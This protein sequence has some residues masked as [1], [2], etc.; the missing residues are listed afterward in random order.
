MTAQIMDMIARMGGADAIGAMAAKLGISPEQTQSAVAA[1]VPGLAG[2]MAKQ[3]QAGN[4]GLVDQLAGAAAALTSSAASDEAVAQGN[5]IVG[6]VLDAD[7][8]AAVTAKAAAAS[9]LDASSLS[10]LMPMVATMA[11]SA[12]GNGTG[13]VAAPAGGGIGG[14]LGGLL[15]NLGGGQAGQGGAAS[16]LMAMIDT[17]KD[18]NPLDEIMGMASG[19][20]KR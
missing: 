13:T 14:M 15:G 20:F 18:G 3:A 11:A 1:M 8:Q 12:L 16:A 5:E 4:G 2:G 7:A 9:G 19:F 6:N 10:A 17:N